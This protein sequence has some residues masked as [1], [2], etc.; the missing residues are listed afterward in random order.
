MKRERV[1]ESSGVSVI[2]LITAHYSRDVT[3]HEVKAILELV[4]DNGANE[5]QERI[6]RLIETTA[7]E[8]GI[9][10]LDHFFQPLEDNTENCFLLPDYLKREI[11]LDKIEEEYDDSAYKEIIKAN[12]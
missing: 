8:H 12:S 3:S 7:E 2:E 10:Y 1:G 6:S 5:I 11:E 4:N 9:T